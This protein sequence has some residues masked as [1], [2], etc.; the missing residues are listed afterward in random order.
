MP[1]NTTD[2]LSVRIACIDRETLIEQALIWGK[3]KEHR[4]I[5]YSN[6]NSLNIASENI[7]FRICLNQI[8]LVYA[9][10]IGVVWAG[11]FLGKPTLHKVTGRVWIDD[12]CKQAAQAGIRLY[13][14]GGK[15][16]VAKRAAEVLQQRYPELV[17]CG[18][19]DGYF[20]TRR[21]QSVLEDL[22]A[23]NPDILLVGMG[24]PIQEL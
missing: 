7:E 22:T 9:D 4:T 13:L 20:H 2:I 1:W 12:F 3:S 6:A 5:A 23:I 14:L 8:D 21:E 10:G 17:I 11:K 19:A 18:T 16:G 15:P 24:T